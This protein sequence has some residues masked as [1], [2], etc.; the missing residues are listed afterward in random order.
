MGAQPGCTLLLRNRDPGMDNR[1][2]Q[3][4][5]DTPL[6]FC[7]P[8]TLCPQ[9]RHS[10]KS[11]RTRFRRTHQNVHTICYKR[12][13]RLHSYGPR[14]AHLKWLLDSDPAIRW[15]VMKDLTDD[16]P[17][18]LQPSGLASQPKTGEHNFSLSN[19]LL[20]T[21]AGR[22]TTEACLLASTLSSS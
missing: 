21:G 6:T 2:F 22:R 17:T 7:R 15:Q 14:P 4:Q 12:S 3:S 1:P 8:G 20:A 11:M 9:P 5:P 19:L 13:M 16:T 18:R 10:Q